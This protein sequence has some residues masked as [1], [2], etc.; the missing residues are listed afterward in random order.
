M[1]NL[2]RAINIDDLRRMAR[3][4]LP[5]IMF[6]FIEGGVEDEVG[7]AT[8]EAAFRR[9]RLVPRYYVDTAARHQRTQVFGQTFSAP[10]GIAP[11]GL[12]GAFYPD[13]EMHLAA[14]AAA[15]NIPY[16][17]SGA[18]NTSMEQAARVAP[19]HLWYQIY[20]AK[21]RSIATDLVRRAGDC[22]VRTI[23]V[24]ADVPVSSNRERNRRNG[25]GRPLRLGI[26]TILE[27]LL[28]PSWL[29]H[30]LRHGIPVMGNWAPY[31]PAGASADQVSDMFATQTPD[32]SQTWQD[33]EAI[34]RLWPHNL[35]VKGLL[36]PEDARI[37]A[38]MG[39]DGIVV[40]NHGGR[41]LDLAPSPLDVLPQIRAVVGPDMVLALDSGVRRGSDAVVARCL[42]ADFVMTGRASLYGAI[43]GGTEGVKKAISILHR[44]IDL[45]LGQLG[46][47]DLAAL[48][49]HM[50]LENLWT[51]ALGEGET[52]APQRDVQVVGARR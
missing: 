8:N 45:T 30:Y 35:M 32:A 38:G 41:Q 43:A 9:R 28:H 49:P 4:R 11:T 24:T 20:G 15:M 52:L 23:V 5:R 25:F 12:A 17:M 21:D 14:G 2:D 10:L 44:E 39:I 3:R 40:S 50:L 47:V 29:L 51:T 33:L 22:G 6:D 19:D 26:G 31:A 18:A 7:L 36:H 1:S 13:A 37:A 42:G 48:G 34:R 27:S 46:C 16:L